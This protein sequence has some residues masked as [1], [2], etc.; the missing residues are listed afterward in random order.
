MYT[1]QSTLA[2]YKIRVSQNYNSPRTM[3]GAYYCFMTAFRYRFDYAYFSLG[4]N[5]FSL[6]SDRV[7]KVFDEIYNRMAEIIAGSTFATTVYQSVVDIEKTEGADNVLTINYA[8]L[9]S[10]H[11]GP[12]QHHA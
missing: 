12:D 7:V 8:V 6:P 3:M 9:P 2:T 10:H 1:A 11:L 4:C 5:G